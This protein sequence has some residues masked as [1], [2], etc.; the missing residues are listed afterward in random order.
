MPK[1]YLES[2]PMIVVESLFTLYSSRYRGVRFQLLEAQLTE[3]VLEMSIR[4]PSLK[5]K[6]P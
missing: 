6:R 2:G 1:G 3:D 4:L 5:I